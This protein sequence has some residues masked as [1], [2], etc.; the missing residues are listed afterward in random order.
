MITA[1]AVLLRI[2]SNSTANLYQKKSAEL[3]SPILVNLY[4]YLLMS[5]FC[6]IPALFINWNI[7]PPIFWV[8][9]VFAGLLCTIGTIA[10]IAAL[11][12]GDLS[13]LAPINSYKSVIGLIS[14]IFILKEFPNT[15]TVQTPSGGYHFYYRV[16][17]LVKCRVR[18]HEEIDIRGENGYVVGPG[19][20]IN[21]KFYEIKNNVPIAQATESVYSFMEGYVQT[22][23]R[24]IISSGQYLEGQ[25][26]DYL[27][28]MACS[29]QSKGLDD[30][31]ICSAISIENEKKC[32]P[33][34]KQS[35]IERLCKSSMRYEKG[36]LTI[37]NEVTCT[38]RCI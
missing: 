35:E 30:D 25:R 12:I 2:F 34:L 27:F 36:N 13:V 29:L 18:V 3:S 16:D 37:K 31:A 10:L 17:R 24:K 28:R 32:Y 9:V 14:A 20:C 15:F 21:G 26:N 1:F 38:N 4:S 22:K 19:S 23:Q 33:P 7:Y 11:K 8:Y 6:I 5:L